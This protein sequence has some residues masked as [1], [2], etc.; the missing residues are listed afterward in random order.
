MSRVQTGTNSTSVTMSF[1]KNQCQLILNLDEDGVYTRCEIMTIDSDG[2][3]EVD[4]GFAQF[5][6]EFREKPSPCK[7]IVKSE[8]LK[9]ALNELRDFNN[10]T[11]LSVL[12]SPQPPHFQI[13]AQ[14]R[15]DVH[16]FAVAQC[17]QT[18]MPLPTPPHPAGSC[19]R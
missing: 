2:D 18:D 16:P 15:S 14:G 13:S 3:A 5:S 6:D 12:L 7:C 9:E 1:D 4:A 11:K 17:L 19:S 10:A 8:Q